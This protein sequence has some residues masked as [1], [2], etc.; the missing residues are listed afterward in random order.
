MCTEGHIVN[1]FGRCSW[2]IEP[3]FTHIWGLYVPEEHRNQ[4]HARQLMLRAVEEVRA[5]GYADPIKVV[6]SSDD[7]TVNH[8]RLSAFYESLGLEVYTYYG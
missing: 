2:T 3:G 7:I 8:K 4:G 5:N 1:Q 6:A